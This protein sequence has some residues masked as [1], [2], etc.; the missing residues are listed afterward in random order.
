MDALSVAFADALFTQFPVWEALAKTAIGEAGGRDYIEVNLP[1]EG[2]DR[3]LYLSTADD[4]ITIGF[5]HWHTHV[6]PFLGID[7][8]ESVAQAMA[9]IRDFIDELSVVSISYRDGVWLESGL[10]YRAAPGALKPQTTTNVF[11]W[12]RTFDTTITTP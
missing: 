11:S 9:I 6:G 1:Q 12:R 10:G 4:E 7:I 3:K 5:D 2:T 8:E